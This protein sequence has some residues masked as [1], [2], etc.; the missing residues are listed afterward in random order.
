MEE[1][2]R[3][4]PNQLDLT[5][6]KPGYIQDFLRQ[7]GTD[8]DFLFSRHS[9]QFVP[10]AKKYKHGMDW[11]IVTI[12]A[13]TLFIRFV[14]DRGDVEELVAG[15]NEDRGWLSAAAVSLLLLLR[16]EWGNASSNEQ[17]IRLPPVAVVLRERF[18]D[19]EQA[20]LSE[21]FGQ[22]RTDLLRIQN[23]RTARTLD[24]FHERPDPGFLAN[25]ARLSDD[26]SRVPFWKPLGTYIGIIALLPLLLLALIFMKP[27]L[28]LLR[29]LKEARR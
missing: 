5:G 9:A 16:D 1:A 15:Q 12:Q 14:R 17:R 24:V 7:Q 10:N 26:I 3:S 21:Q 27:T 11:A 19:F 8:Y 23:M 18:K 13:E 2:W 20:L 28:F 22:T 29:K 6:W 25:Y 4:T